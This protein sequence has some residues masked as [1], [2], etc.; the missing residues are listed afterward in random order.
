MAYRIRHLDSAMPIALATLTLLAACGG[1]IQPDGGDGPGAG[2][3]DERPVGPGVEGQEGPVVTPPTAPPCAAPS[4]IETLATLGEDGGA[5]TGKLLVDDHFVYVDTNRGT[6]RVAKCGGPAVS[7]AD[8]APGQYAAS[9]FVQDAAF[10]YLAAS[11]PVAGATIR[12][13]A[14]AGGL[15]EELARGRDL[16]GLAL[17]PVDA[18]GGARLYWVEKAASGGS[19]R[20]MHLADRTAE[21]VAQLPVA[22]GYGPFV[23]DASGVTFFAHTGNNRGTFYTHPWSGVVPLGTTANPYGIVAREGQGGP[24]TL[25]FTF[26]HTTE[27][28]VARLSRGAEEAIALAAPARA[29]H[30]LAEKDGTL[31]WADSA[32]GTVQRCVLSAESSLCASAPESIATGEDD[33]RNVAVDAEAVYW[34]TRKGT[35]KRAPR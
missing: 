9:G 7:I 17:A 24:A 25:Y 16:F 33:P 6:T 4:G 23:A 8:N 29:P 15:V 28:G 34:A 31:Y 11:A 27:N 12:R 1:A 30:G 35:L 10:V 18:N 26:G 32:A 13:I 19:L 3:K 20:V 21:T 22:Y 14:K 5:T 2:A